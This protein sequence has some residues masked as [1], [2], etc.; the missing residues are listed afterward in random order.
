[1][2]GHARSGVV[3]DGVA[4]GLV[5]VGRS[6]VARS[7]G[8][9][10]EGLDWT[11]P[12]IR[13]YVYAVVEV[14]ARRGACGARDL[15]LHSRGNSKQVDGTVEAAAEVETVALHTCRCDAYHRRKVAAAV[16]E[17]VLGVWVD[18]AVVHDRNVAMHNLEEVEQEDILEV[19]EDSVSSPTV[20]AAEA[21][22]EVV[23]SHD[24]EDAHDTLAV[25]SC[26]Q[27]KLVVA[28][29]AANVVDQAVGHIS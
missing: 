7:P 3:L 11:E 27:Q 4:S 17:E 5:L 13:R 24:K 22:A 15:V 6:C 29:A 2:F 28:A 14:A 18:S 8:V 12:V 10:C 21:M 16:L 19:V 20:A 23:L 1:M 25:Q 9:L 26:F